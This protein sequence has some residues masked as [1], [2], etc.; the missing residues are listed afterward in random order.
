MDF[1]SA[2]HD[3]SSLSGGAEISVLFVDGPHDY[4]SQPMAL[5]LAEPHMAPAGVIAIDDA[6]Y[7]HVRQATWDFLSTHPD[8]NLLAEIT[9]E[10]HPAVQNDAETADRLRRGWSNGLH[11]LVRDPNSLVKFGNKEPADLAPF[12][13]SHDVFRHRYGAI[14]KQ[15]LDSLDSPNGD[16]AT[17]SFDQTAHLLEAFLN[18]NPHRTPSQNTETGGE[19]SFSLARLEPLQT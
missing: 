13:M 11:I 9:T 19:F 1:E 17:Q 5:I 18:E 15:I 4:R 10:G 8:W 7:R 6:N 2:L 16:G 3:W 12:Y 14:A